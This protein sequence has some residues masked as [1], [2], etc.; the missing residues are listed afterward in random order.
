MDETADFWARQ[1]DELK[2][3]ETEIWKEHI[4]ALESVLALRDAAQ[5]VREGQR[6]FTGDDWFSQTLSR[7][8]KDLET[9]RALGSDAVEFN[10]VI[11]PRPYPWMTDDV[12]NRDDQVVKAIQDD[13]ARACSSCTVSPSP[14]LLASPANGQ[15]NDCLGVVASK[16]IDRN[17]VVFVE[18]GILH[19]TSAPNRCPTCARGLSERIGAGFTI[20]C[21]GIRFCSATCIEKADEVFHKPI[22]GRDFSFL[23]PLTE[24]A[25][26]PLDPVLM[27]RILAASIQEGASHPLKSRTVARYKANYASR[28]TAFNFAD[29][30]IKP[31]RVLLTLGIDIFADPRYDTWVL[32]TIQH[33]IENNSTA[34]EL[35]ETYPLVK[36]LRG[37]PMLNHSCE[38]NVNNFSLSADEHGK[39]SRNAIAA[40]RDIEKGEELFLCFFEGNPETMSRADRQSALF[41]WLEG[42][43]GCT[44]CEREKCKE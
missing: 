32:E 22:C 15:A 34:G 28:G 39:S 10:G 7:L 14:F 19:A 24:A 17:E 41:S 13:F 25:F 18:D 30:I 3:L 35:D 27:L 6:K 42:E 4:S 29:R 12:L 8:E 40:I 23:F 9:L 44:R 11:Y 38:P 36:L 21:C 20:P 43:C 31:N 1:V 2:L 33:R 5:M 26:T 37:Y 16:N